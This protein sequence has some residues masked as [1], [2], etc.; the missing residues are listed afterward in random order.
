VTPE[1][2]W[3]KSSASNP[4]EAFVELLRSASDP[5]QR[6][7]LLAAWLN[8]ELAASG[9]RVAVVGGSA[10]E[11]Y[12]LGEYAT[13]DLDLVTVDRD[14]VGRLLSQIGF[15]PDNRYWIRDDLALVVEI[16]DD[17][18]LVG[19]SPGSWE[20]ATEVELPPVGTAI[21][22]SAED[23][24]I[25]RLLAA[26]YWK[27]EGSRQWATA[28]LRYWASGTIGSS[29]DRGYLERLARAE[30]VEDLFLEVEREI[31]GSR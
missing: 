12:T 1:K 23:L 31:G 9:G 11:F 17:Q 2:P 20:R 22:I 6:R 4:R 10:L 19:G 21:V 3:S 15:E 28:L 13:H 24:L 25:D 29:L 18:L 26:K 7:L 27:D 14:Q 5:L 30:Q 16:P 8:S